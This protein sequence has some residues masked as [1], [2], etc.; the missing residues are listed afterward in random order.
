VEDKYNVAN[1]V[2][3]YTKRFPDILDLFD[4]FS[5]ICVNKSDIGVVA[6]FS[7]EFIQQFFVDE[8]QSRLE[9]RNQVNSMLANQSLGIPEFQDDTNYNMYD[10]TEDV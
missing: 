1:I 8:F 10:Q 4:V 2:E 6:E 5:D 9:E 7:D 3:Y